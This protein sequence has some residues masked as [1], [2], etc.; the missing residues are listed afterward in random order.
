MAIR[1][2][3]SPCLFGLALIYLLLSFYSTYFLN[4]MNH[5]LGRKELSREA[6]RQAAAV[7]DQTLAAECVM[8]IWHSTGVNRDLE[9]KL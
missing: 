6:S 7:I 5:P 8:L 9:R 3:Q 1:T 4:M 2:Y